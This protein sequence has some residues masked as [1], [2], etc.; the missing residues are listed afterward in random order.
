MAKLHQR[1]K[2]TVQIWNTVQLDTSLFKMASL[3]KRRGSAKPK[4]SLSSQDLDYLTQNTELKDREVLQTQ[5]DEFIKNHPK[6]YMKQ[7]DFEVFVK[8][9]YPTK[10]VKK[11]QKRLF[12]MLDKDRDGHIT[13][14]EFMMVMCIMANGTPDQN[15]RQIFKM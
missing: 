9:L 5:F 11:I 15:L 8:Q 2:R 4:I 7:K 12:N 3:F 6:G 10:N 1:I 14:R 13:F